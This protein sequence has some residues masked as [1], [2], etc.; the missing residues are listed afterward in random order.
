MTAPDAT[1]VKHAVSAVWRCG[2]HPSLERQDLE[3]IGWLALLEAQAAGKLPDDAGHRTAYVLRR[4]TGAMIDAS[5]AA[6]RRGTD[7]V[8]CD[9]RAA[10]VAAALLCDPSPGPE[11][12][13]D[14]R[15]QLRR[16][17][18][19][20]TERACEAVALMAEHMHARTV[21][22]HMGIGENAAGKLLHRAAR[23]VGGRPKAAKKGG[24]C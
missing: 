14:A 15:M 20:G 7:P 2:T 19:L 10:D 18:A 4:M 16:I 21:A 9:S 24:R 1:L 3:Q 6:N 23:L 11:R 22:A 5:R 12:I 8:L 13:V 17:M